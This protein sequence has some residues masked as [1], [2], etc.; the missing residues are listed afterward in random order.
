[1]KIASDAENQYDMPFYFMGQVM[2]VNFQYDSPKELR[3][4]GAKNGYQH[5]YLEGHGKPSS[6]NTKLSWLGNGNFYTLT[7]ATDTSDEMLF[8]RLGANDPDFN[9]RRDAGF[10]IRRK[11]SKNTVFVS[12]IESHGN[13]SPVSEFAVNSNSAISSLELVYDDANYTAIN[14]KDIKG[15]EQLFI[16]SNKDATNSSK[17]KVT[18]NNQDYEWTGPFNYQKTN[19]Q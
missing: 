9:L 3:A 4:L 19:K 16:L 8:T 17:H 14:I 2:K 18:I 6:D 12:L 10:M 11:N 7:T 15:S 13:Y 1:M 5:L